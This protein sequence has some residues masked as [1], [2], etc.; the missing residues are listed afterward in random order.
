MDT[1]RRIDG[2]PIP[3][4]PG[5]TLVTVPEV[6]QRS[7]RRATARRASDRRATAYRRSWMAND[8]R[9][10]RV[11]RFLRKSSDTVAAQHVPQL[12]QLVG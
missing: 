1:Q 8:E 11:G 7:A 3:Q 6:P 2:A 4:S 5:S 9:V 10:T 12:G